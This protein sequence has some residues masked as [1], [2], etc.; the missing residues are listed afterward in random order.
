[1][2]KVLSLLLILVMVLSMAACGSKKNTEGKLPEG[3]EPQQTTEPSIPETTEAQLTAIE[4]FVEEN[5]EELLSP[6]EESFAT[7]SGMTCTSDVRAEGNGIIIDININ[8]LEGLGKAEKDLM[9]Q[10]YNTAS[11]IFGQMLVA[12]RQELPELEYMTINICEADG[13]VIATIHV[14]DETLAQIPES[15]LSKIQAYVDAN[16]D[17]L[18]DVFVES[19]T[20]ESGLTCDAEI[21]AVGNGIEMAISINELDDLTDSEKYEMQGTYDAMQGEFDPMLEALQ[22][23]VP[24]LDYLIIYICEVDGDLAAY[25]TVDGVGGPNESVYAYVE[26]NYEE[27]ISSTEESFAT[28]SGKTC[29]TYVD[30]VGNGIVL[31]MYINELDDLTDAQK[32][33][34]QASFDS[35]NASYAG[36]MDAMRQELP[37]LAFY[38]LNVCEAD[39][40][41][42]AA[43]VL[44]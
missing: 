7:S 8:E 20:A 3:T 11:G 24:E 21:W 16:G 23:E 22:A 10:S 14:D 5:R 18:L 19:F 44:K 39:G 31:T 15:S 26:E 32:Q 28:S 38:T 29:E 25:I 41:V 36:L 34:Y 12:Y 6:M 33:T 30:V 1:M 37:E 35:L 4:K 17:A 13:D 9:Q 2:K 43:I 27:M 40:D 42:I